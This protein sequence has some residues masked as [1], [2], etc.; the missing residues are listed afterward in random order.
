MKKSS[1]RA[2]GL[3]FLASALI[4]AS[5]ETFARG[6]SPVEGMTVQSIFNSNQELLEEQENQINDLSIKESNL[7]DELDKIKAEQKK[8]LEDLKNNTDQVSSL[9]KA[10][11]SLLKKYGGDE[12]DT[13]DDNTQD[14]Q[15]ENN[16]QTSDNQIITIAPGLASSDIAQQLYDQGLIK[17]AKAFSD[18]IDAW[19]LNEYIQANDY[20]LNPT[21]SMDEILSIITNGA[22][23]Y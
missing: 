4:T 22:Y 10:N 6:N 14:N 21:M 8:T 12:T 20:E 2:I 17:D 7:N 18:L 5:F 23:Y 1:L 16:N 3:A 9:Q 15:E 11:A 19:D 13:T